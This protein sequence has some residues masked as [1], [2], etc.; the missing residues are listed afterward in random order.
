MNLVTLGSAIDEARRFLR[1]A[2][3]PEHAVKKEPCFPSPS[4]EA[5]AVKRASMD[6]SRALSTMRML[7]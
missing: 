3:D 4:K 5:A 1:L 6:L 7:G 2:K